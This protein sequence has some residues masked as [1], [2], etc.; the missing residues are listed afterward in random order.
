MSRSNLK[1]VV[2]QI[3]REVTRYYPRT[4]ILFGSAARH[5][6]GLQTE[7]PE[8]ID[9]L[10]V[11]TL[12]PI[13]KHKYDIPVDLF[14]FETREILSIAKSLRYLPKATARSKMFFKDNWRGYVRADIAACL[15]LG[16]AYPA[17]GFLQMEGEEQYR[18]YSVHQVLHGA[19]WW[20]AL[21]EYAQ[22]HRG[23]MGLGIDKILGLDRFKEPESAIPT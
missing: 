23:V 10:Y 4:V 19:S 9:L 5:L 12:S 17:Y 6:Q 21:Q 22:E 15:L 16:P 20:Y 7:S 8:D 18:D 1:V 14:F 2:E 11:G 13:E 3:T